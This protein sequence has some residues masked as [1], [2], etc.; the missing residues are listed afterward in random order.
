MAVRSKRSVSLPPELARDIERAATREKT[1]FSGW[2]AMTAARRLKLDKSRRLIA[3]WE[4]EDGPFTAAELA[5]ADARVRRLLGVAESK[6][7]R[8]TA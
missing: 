6:R 1:T 3:E 2:I 7:A 8:R 4:R 5:D